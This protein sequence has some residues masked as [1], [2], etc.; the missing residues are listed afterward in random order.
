MLL[1]LSF[2]WAL[3]SLSFGSCSG[4]RIV[5]GAR[6]ETE[7]VAEGRG[8]NASGDDGYDGNGAQNFSKVSVLMHLLYNVL[9]TNF[10]EFSDKAYQ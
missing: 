8:D 4:G 2:S 1:H 9:Y 3:L 6:G 7:A 10:S 5:C